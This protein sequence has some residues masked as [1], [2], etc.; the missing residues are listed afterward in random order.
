[1]EVPGDEPSNFTTLGSEICEGK[2]GTA[3]IDI[4][5]PSTGTPTYGWYYED[6][7]ETIN[8]LRMD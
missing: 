8:K 4:N 1:M 3:T 2:V 5:D 7:S 6:A